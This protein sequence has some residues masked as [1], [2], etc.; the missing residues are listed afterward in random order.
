MRPSLRTPLVIAIASV[1][2]AGFTGVGTASAGGTGPADPGRTSAEPPTNTGLEPPAIWPSKDVPS[3][4]FGEATYMG[5]NKRIDVYETIIDVNGQV[6]TP[7]T[8]A[9]KLRLITKPGKNGSQTFIVTSLSKVELLSLDYRFADPA[10]PNTN[11]VG[12][13]ES[14]PIGKHKVVVSVPRFPV[15]VNG[16]TTWKQAKIIWFS[17]SFADGREEYL[18]YPDGT[19]DMIQPSDAS[20]PPDEGWS[21][22]DGDNNRPIGSDR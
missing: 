18:S 10:H 11:W 21:C 15:K 16:R 20:G 7:T 8:R 9:A 13:D 4:S 19:S 3:P 2:L 12:P 1:L 5:Y 6:S 17:V 22:N 14:K